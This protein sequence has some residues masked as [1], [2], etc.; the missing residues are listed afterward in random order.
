MIRKGLCFA[1][2]FALAAA[3]AGAARAQ[4]SLSLAE[5][6]PSIMLYSGG[7]NLK[8]GFADRYFGGFFYNQY[9]GDVGLHADVVEVSR[10]QDVGFGAFGASWQAAPGI[11]PKIMLGS[12]TNNT[13]IEPD[14]Y[15][16][17][18][19]QIRPIGD[20]RT[21]ITPSVTYRHFR[22]GGEE[23]IPGFDAVYYFSMAN[24][25]DGY[26]VAQAGANVGFTKSSD[27][28]YTLGLGLQTVRANGVS[29]G[30]YGEG[31]RM[32]YN[33]ILSVPGAATNFYSI[34]PS[35]GFRFTPDYEVFVRGE[36]THTGFYDAAG[37]LVGLKISF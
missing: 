9:V 22:N 21:I 17:F 31:G 2:M 7:L 36:Y 11:R 23:T 28:S 1:A 3:A 12:S 30:V 32:V 8:Q 24:D 20:T 10:E 13:D 35:I 33:P 5:E 16:S 27:H 19:V 6:R 26:Y 15:G 34:R 14:V 25:P 18:Q 4:A 37:A 29:F